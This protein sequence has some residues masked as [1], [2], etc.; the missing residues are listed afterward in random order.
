M[1][2]QVTVA[3]AVVAVAVAAAVAIDPRYYFVSRVTLDTISYL[4]SVALECKEKRI[5]VFFQ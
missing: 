3:A 5:L 2:F 4:G 1:G